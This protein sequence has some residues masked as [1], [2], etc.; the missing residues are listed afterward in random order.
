MEKHESSELNP[1]YMEICDQL[2]YDTALEIYR[3]FRG[4][5]ISFPIRFFAKEALGEKIRSE[6]DGTNVRALASK[7]GYSE[8]TVRRILKDK[9]EVK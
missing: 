1:V 8:K 6:Y 2:G 5:Q 3:L 7:Y 4:Q 9:K